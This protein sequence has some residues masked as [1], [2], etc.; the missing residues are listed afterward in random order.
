MYIDTWKTYLRDTARA[1]LQPASV[2]AMLYALLAFIATQGVDYY[3]HR[4]DA[5]EKRTSE[6]IVSFIESTK[7]FDTLVAILAHSIM[8]S[9]SGTGAKSQL[10]T[11]INHQYSELQYLDS[12]ISDKSAAAEY[13]AS[14]VRLN[15]EIS[16]VNGTE[17]MKGYWEAVSE[18]LTA[19]KKLTTDLSGRLTVAI[20]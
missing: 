18:V 10:R 20:N 1:T 15:D 12:L 13:R 14:L 16:S 17:G 4:Q 5:V 11:N 8:D 7:Q 2:L 19:R 6:Q 9:E 3:K